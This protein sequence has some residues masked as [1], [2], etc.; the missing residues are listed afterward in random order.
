VTGSRHGQ[1]TG[2]ELLVTSHLTVDI[3]GTKT[4]C[5][6]A[7]GDGEILARRE[8]HTPLTGGP[9]ACLQ[10]IARDLRRVLRAAK[11]QLAAPLTSIGVAVGG[12]LDTR[13]GIVYSPPNL[14]G[15]DAVPVK[16]FLQQAFGLPAFVENDA[17]AGALA[18]HRFGAGRR[19]R[20]LV[21]LTLGTG[22]GG[23]II[24]D[25]RL[26]RGTTDDAGE[27]GH[28]TILP[29]GPPCLCGKRGC[30]EALVAGPAIAKRAQRLAQDHPNSGMWDIPRRGARHGARRS[31]PPGRDIKT[32]TSETALTAARQ[33]DRAA[34]EVWRETGHYLGIGIANL[35][36][37][38]NPQVIVLG[39]IAVHAGEMLLR[40]TRR[41]A[42]EHTWPRAW[43]AVRIVPAKLGSKV[44]DLAALCC[45]L[46]AGK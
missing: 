18:E 45:A 16:D 10:R 12:P 41:S 25:G 5:A 38:L 4:A 26:Y 23:G 44:G 33:G 46:N 31:P 27:I 40:P 7:T 43:K 42:R 21:Y 32:L 29:D 11:A 39:T 35:I 30:L 8:H 22:I 15:W 28:T 37:V 34:R 2:D 9:E 6:V 13:T 1:A 36:Q 17:N 3:G 14:P 24:M 19:A 20:N